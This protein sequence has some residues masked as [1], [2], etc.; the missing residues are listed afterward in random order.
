[1]VAGRSCDDCEKFMWNDSE[2][3]GRMGDRILTLASGERW[4]RPKGIPTPCHQCPKVPREKRTARACRK[5]AI[6]PTERSWAIL[7]H[8][9]ACRAVGEFRGADGQI[10]PLV[11]R[12]AGLIAEVVRAVERAKLDSANGLLG[13]L[14]SAR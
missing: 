3:S 8:Y 1:M 13:L 2:E 14:F 7:W 12:H 4:E 11:R 6:E 5:D 10:D 9:R